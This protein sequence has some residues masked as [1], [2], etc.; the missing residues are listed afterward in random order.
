MRP[1]RCLKCYLRR[2]GGRCDFC[3]LHRKNRH[4]YQPIGG[5]WFLKKEEE[6]KSADSESPSPPAGPGAP[7]R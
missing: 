5:G 2:P 7:P 3:P 1:I 6:R 4:L